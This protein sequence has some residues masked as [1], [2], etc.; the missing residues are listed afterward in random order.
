M[1]APHIHYNV[2][3]LLLLQQT[4]RKKKNQHQKT[5]AQEKNANPK[6]RTDGYWVSF[7]LRTR[8]EKMMGSRETMEEVCVEINLEEA[9]KRKRAARLPLHLLL[10]DPRRT[11]KARDGRI[12]DDITT[13]VRFG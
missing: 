13:N 7:D 11:A 10:L 4:Q 6:D 5:K 2:Q 3:K 12:V 9:A 1:L 8:R